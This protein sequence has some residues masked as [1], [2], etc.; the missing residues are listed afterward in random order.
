[1]LKYSVQYFLE[2]EE[3]CFSE[4]KVYFFISHRLLAMESSVEET[5]PRF[6]PCEME[7]V[8]LVFAK[9]ALKSHIHIVSPQY[10]SKPT[11]LPILLSLFLI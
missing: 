3:L 5:G 1:M 8:P 6:T 11:E 10:C 4:D 2:I 9:E 7:I